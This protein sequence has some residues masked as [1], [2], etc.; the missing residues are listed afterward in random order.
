M[1]EGGYGG[2]KGWRKGNKM[3]GRSGEKIFVEEGEERLVGVN[4]AWK[5]GYWIFSLLLFFPT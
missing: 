4:L 2:R 3:V 1:E 5:I